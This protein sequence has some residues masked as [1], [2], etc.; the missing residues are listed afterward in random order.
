MNKC[1]TSFPPPQADKLDARLNA[2]GYADKAKPEV[3]EKTRV[4]LAQKRE[5]LDALARSLES[6]AA[7]P[8]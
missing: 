7:T 2:P 6:L 1:A 3:V 4:D 8:Q 5:T